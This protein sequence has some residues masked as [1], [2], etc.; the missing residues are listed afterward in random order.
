MSRLDYDGEVPTTL[1]RSTLAGV[2]ALALLTGCTPAKP[3]PPKVVTPPPGRTQ[4]GTPAP[5]TPAPGAVPNAPGARPASRAAPVPATA[6]VFDQSL[7]TGKEFLLQ[8][9]AFSSALVRDFDLGP[10]D[11]GTDE[12]AQ[13]A[14]KF[15]A[16]LSGRGFDGG[17]TSQRWTAYLK[18]RFQALKDSGWGASKVRWGLPI[19]PEEGG[20]LR[21]FLLRDSDRAA[22]GLLYLE[23]SSDHWLVTDLQWFELGT[24][25]PFD[26]GANPVT[27]VLP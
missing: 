27:S 11:S 22:K 8:R 14:R 9:Q 12:A 17:L 18:G 13:V 21:P 6:R 1:Y 19:S 4:S 25:L 15:L 20:L 24:S 2:L 23:S 7:L 26:P 16:Q 5:G 3:V 10:L